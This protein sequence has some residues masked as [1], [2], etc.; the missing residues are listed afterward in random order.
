M[1]LY[2]RILQV[3]YKAGQRSFGIAL[4]EGENLCKTVAR[5]GWARVKSGDNAR[6]GDAG[7]DFDEMRRL[8]SDAEVHSLT[9]HTDDDIKSLMDC[10]TSRS[11]KALICP[12][13]AVQHLILYNTLSSVA[14]AC[15]VW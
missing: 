15:M 8:G 14:Q 7:G 11:M 2:L 12:P 6:D 1:G 9:Q 10:R 3:E 13:W 5:E 4:L